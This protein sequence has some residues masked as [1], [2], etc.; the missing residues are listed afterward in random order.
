MK[1]LLYIGALLLLSN[2]T[3]AALMPITQCAAAG[4][5]ANGY[6]YGGLHIN[7]RFSVDTETHG[8]FNFGATNAVNQ[9][10]DPITGKGLV[11]GQGFPVFEDLGL[12]SSDISLAG[13]HTFTGEYW[14]FI[15]RTLML[16]DNQTF[17]KQSISFSGT[18][19]HIKRP[20]SHTDDTTK[21]GPIDIRLKV[22]TNPAKR[23]D[24]NDEP[25]YR[26]HSPHRDKYE[27][28][29]FGQFVLTDP[30]VDVDSGF[31]RYSKVDETA[32]SLF[33]AEVEGR[34]NVSEP[35]TAPMIAIGLVMFLFS[36]MMRRS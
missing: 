23:L 21:G 20:P 15:L 10:N 35:T 26:G 5:G 6:C 29:L 8:V 4:F 9:P 11:D 28:D 30:T 1:H 19:Q 32:F 14:S 22:T 13:S 27:Y 36:R 18:M 24:K 2:V 16:D 33:R 31:V 25:K 3:S 34:H 17:D 12:F 7:A